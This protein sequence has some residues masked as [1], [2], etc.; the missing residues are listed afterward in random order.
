[1][2]FAGDSVLM[3]LRT[4]Y[5][6]GIIE[7]GYDMLADE[8]RCGMQV[9]SDRNSSYWDSFRSFRRQLHTV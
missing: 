5:T 9:A 6:N 2:D 1:V 4:S 3:Q 7:A 8:V